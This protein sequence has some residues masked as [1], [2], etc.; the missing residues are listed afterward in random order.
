ME[1]IAAEAPQTV[2]VAEVAAAVASPAEAIAEAGVVAVLV[3]DGDVADRARV[4]RHQ[5]AS[6]KSKQPKKAQPKLYD[7]LSSR[8]SITIPLRSFFCG[9]VSG[10]LFADR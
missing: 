9:A 8:P 2:R 5:Q 7:L 4:L 10:S 3:V 1:A 6:H